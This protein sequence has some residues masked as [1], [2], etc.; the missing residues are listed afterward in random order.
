MILWLKNNSE[1]ITTVID[2]W[3]KTSSYRQQKLRESYESISYFSEYPSFKSANGFQL[4]SI[5]GLKL[6]CF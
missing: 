5:F 2:K 6:H 1:P 4:V 3:K